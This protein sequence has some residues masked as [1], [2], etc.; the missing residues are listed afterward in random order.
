MQRRIDTLLKL[1]EETERVKGNFDLYQ[2]I[3][4]RWFDKTKV[5]GEEF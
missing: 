1:E 4:K 3:I 2:Q 5:G